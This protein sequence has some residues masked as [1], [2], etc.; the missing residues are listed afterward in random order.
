MDETAIAVT[1]GRPMFVYFAPGTAHAPHHAPR[2]WIDRYEGSFD[3]G[4]DETRR[5]TLSRQKQL[6][7]VPADTRLELSIQ[8]AEPG[9]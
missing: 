3:G 7:I 2:D 8:F 4:W 9:E 6:G 5:A 1:A